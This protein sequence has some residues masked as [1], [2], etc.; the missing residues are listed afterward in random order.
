MFKRVLMLSAIAS[1]GII[2]NFTLFSTLRGMNLEH[3]FFQVSKVSEDQKKKI[4]TTLEEFFS[5]NSSVADRLQVIQMQTRVKLLGGDAD[6]DHSQIIGGCAV[7]L[8]GRICPPSPRVS[9]PLARGA[10][11]PPLI[12]L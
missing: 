8:L 4:F 1:Q 12:G 11:P 5:P 2:G 6:V 7:K 9:A 10:V 3:D